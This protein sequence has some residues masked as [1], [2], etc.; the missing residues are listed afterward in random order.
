MTVIND[1]NWDKNN[2]I[3]TFIYKDKPLRN[4]DTVRTIFAYMTRIIQETD[5]NQGNSDVLEEAILDKPKISMPIIEAMCQ[6][7]GVE[8][9]TKER[10]INFFEL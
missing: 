7:T 3:W 5:W 8:Y 1:S 2:N 10:D 4:Y 6:V 9:M